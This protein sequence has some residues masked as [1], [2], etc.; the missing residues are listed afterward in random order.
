[1][2]GTTDELPGFEERLLSELRQVVEERQSASADTT[3][4]RFARRPPSIPPRRRLPVLAA[5]ALA[6]LL[7]V[8]VIGI[9][10]PRSSD[11][12]TYSMETLPSGQIHVVLAPDFDEAERLRAELEDAGVTVQPGTI[13]AAPA[14]VG[15]IE[16]LPLGT[17]GWPGAAS[18]PDGLEVGDGEF[19][20]DPQRYQGSVELLVYVA[21][22]PGEPWQ[23]APS[24]FHPEEPLGGLPCSLD[25]P[26]TT[27]PLEAAARQV[28]IEKFNWLAEAGDPT[29]DEVHL[30]ESAERPDGEVLAASLRAPGELEVL[31]RP[32]ALVE[33]FGHVG[34]PSMS[35]NLH[36]AEQPVCT[37]Q[38]AARW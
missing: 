32:T 11:A 19:W 34:P 18:K 8:G 24:V 36:D 22:P 23:Q 1:M 15:A 10:A 38:L 6:L 29:G 21:P 27:E 28:G 5:A 16:I 17:H 13:A 12:S 14:L 7:A 2:N 3:T 35:L 9:A 31:V 30:D 4:P 26:L 20:I 33:R 25:G 37:P